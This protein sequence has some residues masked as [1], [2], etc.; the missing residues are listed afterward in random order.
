MEYVNSIKWQSVLDNGEK[1]LFYIRKERNNCSEWCTVENLINKFIIGMVLHHIIE[2][3]SI[4][5]NK[6]SHVV[7]YLEISLK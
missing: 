7:V 6:L 2:W 5:Q 1:L 3:I 4:I